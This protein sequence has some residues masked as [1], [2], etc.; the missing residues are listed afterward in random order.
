MKRNKLA[1]RSASS[2]SK[3][4][5]STICGAATAKGQSLPFSAPV[6]TERETAHR[7]YAARSAPPPLNRQNGCD[8][9]GI[10]RQP[11]LP[12][13]QRHIH[14]DMTCRRNAGFCGWS[15]SADSGNHIH[16]GQCGYP[17]ASAECP[18]RLAQMVNISND[19]AA[20][21]VHPV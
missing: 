8:G 9:D 6:D 18:A 14:S 16:D 12:A 21:I 7:Y 19:F 4:G 5:T 15:I 10:Q 13:T 11:W 2:V 20:G 1:L 3:S 17:A